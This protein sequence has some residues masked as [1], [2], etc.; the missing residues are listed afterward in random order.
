MAYKHSGKP[1][2]LLPCLRKFPQCSLPG[3]QVPQYF[4]SSKMQA[5]CDACFAQ[6]PPCLFL[7]LTRH[8]QQQWNVSD[9]FWERKS[10]GSYH[11]FRVSSDV[12]V[13]AFLPEMFHPLSA[14]DGHPHRHGI[15]KHTA[16]ALELYKGEASSPFSFPSIKLKN[17]PVAVWIS[18]SVY[19]SSKLLCS[20]GTVFTLYQSTLLL[21]RQ[22]NDPYRCP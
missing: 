22:P 9:L 11:G 14:H 12:Q 8:W 10:T 7:S 3:S 18:A 4:L 19:P 17:N 20:I 6:Q 2:L 15:L 21:V 16:A 13:V 1:T 5:T